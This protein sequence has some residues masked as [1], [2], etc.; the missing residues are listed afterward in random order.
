MKEK[1]VE[2][3]VKDFVLVLVQVSVLDW[4][5]VAV[6]VVVEEV[7]LELLIDNDSYLDCRVLASNN[8]VLQS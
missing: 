3:G 5:I 7:V 4:W 6:V 8:H 2:S 1:V